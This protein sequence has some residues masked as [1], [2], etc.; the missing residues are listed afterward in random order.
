MN[1]T[2]LDLYFTFFKLGL[3]TFGGGYVMI[4]LIEKQMI[5][6]K[7]W[8]TKS[9]MYDM[10]ALTQTIPGALAIN[11]SGLVGFRLRKTLGTIVSVLGVM[12]PSIIII[13]II[14]MFFEDLQDI[15]LVQNAL[16]GI[17]AMVVSLIIVSA[18]KMIK[19]TLYSSLQIDLFITALLLIIFTDIKPIFLIILS[20]VLSIITPNRF[21]IR[22]VEEVADDLS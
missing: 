10:M 11:M 16:I 12:T 15:E 18:V 13:T 7:K 21:M 9:D 8:L 20:L 22:D 4:P 14:A 3:F 2:L 19:S 5:E 17:K 1:V 6:E